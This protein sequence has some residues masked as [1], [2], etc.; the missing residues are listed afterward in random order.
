MQVLVATAKPRLL[1]AARRQATPQT[2]AGLIRGSGV[3]DLMKARNIKSTGHNVVVYRDEPGRDLMHSPDGIPVDI[4]AEILEPFQSDD[5]L[6]C[7]ETPSGRFISAVHVGSYEA[8][9]TAYD[10]IFAAVRSQ[11]LRLGGPYWEFYGHWNPDPEM[12]ETTVSYSLL[13]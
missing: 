3:W 2:L 4:G 8:L 5:E 6:V 7:A 13:D 11:G 12:L 10:T 1:A 9:H